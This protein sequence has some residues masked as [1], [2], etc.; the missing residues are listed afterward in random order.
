MGHSMNKNY[1]R[2][3]RKCSVLKKVIRRDYKKKLALVKWKGCL[4]MF[5]S[6][7]PITDV[8]NISPHMI[9]VRKRHLPF[10]MYF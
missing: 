4:D 1:K 7:I 6:W 2:Q 5:N 3:H 9:K 8:K 10:L